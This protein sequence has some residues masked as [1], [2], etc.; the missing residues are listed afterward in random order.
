M[1]FWA[2]IEGV[3]P[4]IFVGVPTCSTIGIL[5]LFRVYSLLRKRKIR[6]YERL[7]RVKNK[8]LRAA[9]GCEKI[10]NVQNNIYLDGIP[11]A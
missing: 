4:T 9:E 7:A 5:G 6:T 10:R 8:E 11:V 1:R 2:Y 3:P